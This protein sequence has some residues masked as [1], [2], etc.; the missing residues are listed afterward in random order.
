M[1]TNFNDEQS[2]LRRSLVDCAAI[3]SLSISLFTMDENVH[4]NEKYMVVITARVKHE[5]SVKNVKDYIIRR[6]T[7]VVRR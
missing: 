1:H 4:K 6:G 5:K 2:F 7:D 3:L